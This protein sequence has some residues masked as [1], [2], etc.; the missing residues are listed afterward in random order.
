MFLAVVF[1]VK[2][3]MIMKLQNSAINKIK[4]ILNCT[5]VSILFVMPFATC[6]ANLFNVLL[7]NNSSSYIVGDIVDGI[8]TLASTD[9]VGPGA[10]VGASFDFP[11][12]HNTVE[13]WVGNYSQALCPGKAE[14]VWS[15]E[16]PSGTTN[17]SFD[18]AQM[19]CTA[20][21]DGTP[22]VCPKS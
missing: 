4:R 7:T 13:Y 9:C 10:T 22:F 17:C 6:Y 1:V 20:A 14:G 16:V 12:T 19:T 5:I 18:G 21:P 15:C 3:E 11:K 8:I 2:L